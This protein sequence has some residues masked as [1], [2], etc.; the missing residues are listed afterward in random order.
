MCPP[1]LLAVQ[2]RLAKE[3]QLSAYKAIECDPGSDV[4]HHLMGRQVEARSRPGGWPGCSGGFA[5]RLPSVCPWAG[6]LV[7]GTAPQLI[8]CTTT[9]DHNLPACPPKQVALRDG[10]DQLCA[11]H[12]GARHVRHRAAAGH[13]TAGAGLVP[14]RRGAGASA[15]HPQVSVGAL[16]WG[17]GW[18]T[19]RLACQMGKVCASAQSCSGLAGPWRLTRCAAHPRCSAHPAR[20]PAFCAGW[21]WGGCTWSSGRCPRPWRCS[22]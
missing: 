2:V 15:P 3:A 1:P 20:L 5:C 16:C 19:G 8:C 18:M 10:A 12:A 4:A 17:A 11:A 22:R 7:K 13:A 14:A 6:R 9:N 21:R